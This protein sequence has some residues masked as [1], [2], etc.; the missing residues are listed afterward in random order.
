M[1]DSAPGGSDLD[2]ARLIARIEFRR[3]LRRA[4]S[5]TNVLVGLGVSAM[6][7]LAATVVGVAAAVIF[8]D[9]LGTL[10][11]FGR[12]VV[13]A[14]VVTLWFVSAVMVAFRAVG[15]T[16]RIDGP[17]GILTATSARSV[18][19]G[20][21]LAELYRLVSYLGLPVVV[22]SVAL[23]VGTG[24]P[25]VGLPL[26]AVVT[27]TVTTGLPVGYLLGLVALYLS[28]TVPFVRRN[29]LRLGV[30]AMLVYLAAVLLFG[31]LVF[32]LARSPLAWL[33]DPMLVVAGAG[34][35]PLLAGAALG[36]P[37]VVVPVIVAAATR[38]AERTWYA[39]TV[40][41]EDD[42]DAAT[43]VS[44]VDDFLAPF[45]SRPTASVTRKTLLRAR[46]AP[47]TLTFAFVPALAAIGY[48]SQAVRTGEIPGSFPVLAAAYAGW[49]VGSAFTLNPFGDEGALLPVT[50]STG[51]TGH[52]FVRG[53]VLAAWLVG[54]PVAL[55][56]VSVAAVAAAI[57]PW[58][59]AGSLAFA[60]VFSLA[61]PLVSA[62]IGAA[63]PKFDTRTVIAN[64]EAVVPSVFAF[65]L[66]VLVL[67]PMGAPAFLGLSFAGPLG[68]L[69][70]LPAAVIAALGVAVTAV[71]SLGAGTASFLFAVG[72]F[73]DYSVE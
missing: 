12:S 52:Q 71:V 59:A 44:G 17:D 15:E 10:G 42:D 20:L 7:L 28:A 30:L 64:R 19:L 22:V 45:V 34:G 2:H 55:A 51:A 5:E 48:V 66:F 69:L 38:V 21:L 31:D 58:M 37:V 70:D 53:R 26:V 65:G 14:G 47:Y 25:L 29:R 13:R 56:V 16:G 60:F 27:A 67:L 61:G 54:L 3:S 24:D 36:A 4:R 73:D 40:A 18:V 68:G 35:D 46:R 57:P 9:R 50:L 41:P 63:F 32:L 1:T 39:D 11:A 8:G 43:V 23:A 62:G 33:A 6:M 49:G 72:R